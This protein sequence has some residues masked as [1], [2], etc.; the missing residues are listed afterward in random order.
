[1]GNPTELA[2]KARST[3]AQALQA[4][5]ADGVPEDLM[6]VAEPIAS[7]MG[8]LH[9]I[10]KTGEADAAECTKALDNVRGALDQLQTATASPAVDQAMEAVAG[11][12]S[13]LFA[14]SKAVRPS[15]PPKPPAATTR[16]APGPASV[17]VHAATVADDVDL[18]D[19]KATLPIDNKVEPVRPSAQPVAP[20]PQVAPAVQPQ[21]QHF[22]TAPLAQQA[23]PVPQPMAHA[24]MAAP[25][26]PAQATTSPVAQRVPGMTDAPV[27]PAGA[28]F[29]EVELGAHSGSNF[30]KGLSGNDVVDHGGVF[31][32]TYKIPKVGD[33]VA[34]RVHLPGDL[35]F[36][37]DAVVQWTRETRG[38]DSEPGFGA[39][40]TR[41]SDEGRQL[42][43]RYVK[44]RE[45]MFYD[46]L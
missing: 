22:P 14:L 46:D 44:N 30:Y 13:K 23:A 7:T 28:N 31:V 3:L 43:Y 11:S 29:V 10:E 9:R 21:A 2:N 37:G 6:Q 40:F 20:Q 18:S 12:L 15:A 33:P 5:Q 19:L 26:H 34:L 25:A 32:A 17:D 42:V 4:L 27:P 1:M 45:P 36:D 8:I 16:P 41:I 38:G 39:K 24:P 35:S